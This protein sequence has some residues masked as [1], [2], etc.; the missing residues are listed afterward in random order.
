MESWSELLRDVLDVPGTGYACVADAGSGEILA[1]GGGRDVPGLAAV[2]GWGAAELAAGGPAFEDAVITTTTGHHLLRAVTRDGGPPVLAYAHLD[3]T[4]TPL[5]LVRRALRPAPGPRP[6]T[7]PRGPAAPAPARGTP[8]PAGLPGH[9][10]AQ[11]R[12]GSPARPRMAARPAPPAAAPPGVLPAPA[13]TPVVDAPGDGPPPPRAAAVP[14]AAPPAASPVRGDPAVPVAVPMPSPVPD[15]ER[16]PGPVVPLPRRAPAPA[17]R[18]DPAPA[19]GP[20]AA[21]A[22]ARWADDL[23]TMAR[24]L[25]ALR[26]LDRSSATEY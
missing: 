16:T 3:H 17:P 4:G 21:P 22:G 14:P 6:G 25:A 11:L 26:R 2:L 18:E 19:A 20:G 9:T 13:G 5:A 1:A 23:G 10:N 8:V 7:L 15:A 24:V 12:T